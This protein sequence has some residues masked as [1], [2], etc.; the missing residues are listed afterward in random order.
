MT[1]K[2]YAL[3]ALCLLMAGMTY[4]QKQ[5]VEK[6]WYSGASDPL[7]VSKVI[8]SEDRT[9]VE[10]TFYGNKGTE[11]KL[12]PETVLRADGKEYALRSARGISQKDFVFLPADGQLSFSLTFEPLPAGTTSF[13]LIEKC[14][15]GWQVNGVRLDG[16]RTEVKIP[17]QLKT[18][19]LDYDRPLP[20][21]EPKFGKFRLTGRF[22]GGVPS[23]VTYRTLGWVEKAFMPTPITVKDST[24][25]WEDYV[26]HPE[27]KII[28]F[29]KMRIE[30]LV[31]PDGELAMT[32]DYPAMHL[33]NTHLWGKEYQTRRKIWFEGDYAGLNTALQETPYALD[34]SDR[35]D[36]M[37]SVQELKQAVLANYK[38]VRRQLLADTTLSRPIRDFFLWD[39]EI[40]TFRAISQAGFTVAFACQMRG[41]KVKPGS[42]ERGEH[43]E[44][45]ILAL[46]SIQSPVMMYFNYYPALV[47]S[48]QKR[49][50]TSRK[51]PWWQDLALCNGTIGS[52]LGQ[53]QPLT[54]TWLRT[55]RTQIQTPAIR[56]YIY[57][58]SS[59]YK[60]ALEATEQGIKE[61]TVIRQADTSLQGEAL[62]QSIVQGHKG[63]VVLIDFWNTWC[64]P[65]RN[66]MKKMEP[67]KEKLKGEAI[68]YVFLA[69]ETSPQLLWQQM[70]ADMHGE[71][72]RLSNG[73]S[74][75]L[76]QLYG[77][78]G[79][80]AYLILDREGKAV[81]QHLAFPGA[82]EMEAQ[83]RKALNN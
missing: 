62:L 61:G 37:T 14:E 40:N 10:A 3:L 76:L 81:Y 41:E 15:G 11:V 55:V 33:S 73:Q 24:F 27:L 34:M 7:E 8:L 28:Y 44:D 63:R 31:I 36:G 66:A 9:V 68:D 21:P 49:G 51:R 60:A 52:T 77:F 4:G 30:V 48:L 32:V 26:N 65:C 72:Y 53:M 69:D 46:D 2:F 42:L 50:L 57:A 13:D 25:V 80:P 54:E 78:S 71:H 1:N 45:E 38:E 5:V 56:D 12:T 18:Q 43:F 58:Q 35:L 39:L 67:L 74:A 47:E 29:D 20:A 59:K 75:S 16:K 6:P 19:T 22:L 83:L 17:E 82:E 64:G 23:K 79:I 70:I